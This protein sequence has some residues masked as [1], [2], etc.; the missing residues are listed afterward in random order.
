MDPKCSREKIFSSAGPSED[1]NYNES[2]RSAGEMLTEITRTTSVRFFLYHRKP[3][4]SVSL[5]S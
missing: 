3:F 2:T 1:L 5:E 4:C